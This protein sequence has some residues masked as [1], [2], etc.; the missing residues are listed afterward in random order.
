MEN[1]NIDFL[2]FFPRRITKET[3]TMANTNNKTFKE[4]VSE[5]TDILVANMTRNLTD[6][7]LEKYIPAMVQHVEET[8]GIEI[9]TTELLESFPKIQAAKAAPKKRATPASKGGNKCKRKLTSPQSL[10]RI[11]EKTC[12]IDKD[13]CSACAKIIERAELREKEKAEKEKAEK[14]PKGKPASGPAKN[15]NTAKETAGRLV[16]STK[17]KKTNTEDLKGAKPMVNYSNYFEVKIED[18]VYVFKRSETDDFIFV[19]KLDED[20]NM[21]ELED[22]DT[23]SLRAM[24]FASVVEE[25]PLPDRE[26]QKEDEEDAIP[27]EDDEEDVPVETDAEDEDEEMVED[28]GTKKKVDSI[29]SDIKNKT[30]GNKT[31][32]M[33]DLN[34]K[35]GK[36]VN[37]R[38][39]TKKNTSATTFPK[40]STVSQKNP[41]SSEI[42]SNNK[43][44]EKEDSDEDD[45]EDDE[46]DL[47]DI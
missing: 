2:N 43:V 38:Q 37:S 20:G 27:S 35:K 3:M 9:D 45:D 15:K 26:I 34:G 19:A 12:P 30:T 28:K 25:V 6:L 11:C 7:I 46:C 13:Y 44:E 24:N 5:E 22:S 14:K 40:G 42:K 32:S 21:E 33:K 10:G 18:V 36:P 39:D 16:L 41:T 31:N 23:K 1:N 17:P 4:L 29:V 47:P 8:H